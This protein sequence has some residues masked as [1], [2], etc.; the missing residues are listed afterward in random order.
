MTLFS[1]STISSDSFLWPKFCAYK[2]LV[3][4]F[5]RLFCLGLIIPVHSISFCKA[6]LIQKT[7]SPF[8]KV[9]ISCCH[10]S[11]CIKMWTSGERW[12]QVVGL[13]F[14][15]MGGWE[16][17]EGEGGKL[18]RGIYLPILAQLHISRV[19]LVQVAN[20]SDLSLLI[21]KMRTMPSPLKGCV[22]DY[23]WVCMELPTHLAHYK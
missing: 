19:G 2:G 10:G 13:V 20:L 23:R 22:E 21:P 7:L 15:Q 1:K 8:S 18:W 12:R 3:Q 4:L 16:H 17:M 6:L 9:P 14:K 11:L 5:H